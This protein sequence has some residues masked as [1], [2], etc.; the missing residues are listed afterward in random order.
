LPYH[1]GYL[2]IP[3]KTHMHYIPTPSYF[4]YYNLP[5]LNILHRSICFSDYTTSTLYFHKNIGHSNRTENT[6]TCTVCPLRYPSQMP[7]RI[8]NSRLFLRQ[9]L[10]HPPALNFFICVLLIQPTLLL[11]MCNIRSMDIIPR[12]L[13]QIILYLLVSDTFFLF[14][15][16]DIRIWLHFKG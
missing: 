4:E 12:L 2:I 7:E 5:S 10:R 14:V 8:H 3:S 9:I 13:F 11:Y 16:A 1:L 15:F 6:F